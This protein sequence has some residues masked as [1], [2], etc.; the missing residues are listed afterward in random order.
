MADKKIALVS[1]A[2][3]GLGFEI[4]RQL[5][6]K[7]I[8]VLM[9]ARDKQRGEKAVTELA[10]QGLEVV[11]CEMDV[12]DPDSV[13]KALGFVSKDHGRLDILVN[14]AGVMTEKDQKEPGLKIDIDTVRRTF[15]TNTL[16]HLVVTQTFVPLMMKNNYGRIV[17]MS[18][19]LGT[20]DDMEGGYPAYRI[21]KTA[22]NALTKIFA[23]ELQ[24]TNILVNSM[25]PGWC[26]TD[27]GGRNATRSASD[28]AQTAVYLALL[29][30]NGPTGR[31]FRDKKEIKW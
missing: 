9:A 31:Y 12:T 21:S 20:L 11:F 25:C 19:G 16:G 17:N 24:G 18:S 15:E 1:G 5:A 14:N 10:K 30:D 2:N 7:G 3:K 13:K 29:P 6:E 22:L 28:G 4:S 23:A 26:R 27:M 8:R